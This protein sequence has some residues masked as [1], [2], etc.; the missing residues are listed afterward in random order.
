MPASEAHPAWARPIRTL[1]SSADLASHAVHHVGSHEHTGL[2]KS[3]TN[4]LARFKVRE[5]RAAAT[6]SAQESGTTTKIPIRRRSV[7]APAAPEHVDTQRPTRHCVEEAIFNA[8][9]LYWLGSFEEALGLYAEVIKVITGLI[10]GD[11]RDDGGDKESDTL[12]LS[13]CHSAM[14]LIY[15]KLERWAEAEQAC[16][17]ALEGD[18]HNAKALYRRAEARYHLDNK[19]GA[20]DDLMCYES[21]DPAGT[22]DV[23]KLDHLLRRE[24][25]LPDPVRNAAPPSESDSSCIAV[26]AGMDPDPHPEIDIKGTHAGIDEAKSTATELL[27]AGDLRGA[28][29]VYSKAIWMWTSGKTTDVPS[30]IM[31]IIFS[32][33]ARVELDLQMYHEAIESCDAGLSLNSDSAKLLVRR[34]LANLWS[35]RMPTAEQDIKAAM[36]IAPNDAEVL[37]TLELIKMRK[38]L[39]A[40]RTK[41]TNM[42]R[43]NK[44]AG[45][46]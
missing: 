28:L 35:S 5:R 29:A 16:S 40:N 31:V 12:R 6:L 11:S 17:S 19:V 23:Y 38:R 25:R 32:H 44:L 1:R 8:D 27:E 4:H 34:A 26:P 21:M 30:K 43:L 10:E 37:R 3:A 45:S 33:R 18:E 42:S 14:A 36:A 2:L 41:K 7:D 22:F 15:T 46:F 9:T 20:H 39:M 13:R 24:L